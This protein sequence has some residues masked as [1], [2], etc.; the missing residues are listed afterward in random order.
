[1][2]DL[3]KTKTVLT[4]GLLVG[5]VFSLLIIKNVYIA[6]IIILIFGFITGRSFYYLMDKS[7]YLGYDSLLFFGGLFLGY[8]LGSYYAN[9]IAILVF[10]ASGFGL[11]YYLYKNNY[12][13]I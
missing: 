7:N 8:L 5:L 10:F 6:Y 12:L 1:M 11:A 13:D 9:R 3:I 4:I 2:G